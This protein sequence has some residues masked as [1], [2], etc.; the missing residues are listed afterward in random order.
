MYKVKIEKISNN[1][2]KFRTSSMEGLAPRLPTTGESFI[3]L[4]EGLNEG[5]RTFNT[6]M[7]KDFSRS[8]EES[9]TVYQVQT[10]NSIYKV[11]VLSW[12]NNV[13]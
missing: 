10:L 1:P 2:N 11:T 7:V 8:Q 5:I 6:S 4:G 12:P 9:Y 3:V 13:N